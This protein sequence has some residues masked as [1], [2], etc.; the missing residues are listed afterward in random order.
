MIGETNSKICR[1]NF[2]LNF[3][4]VLGLVL[5]LMLA[6]GTFAGAA[7]PGHFGY[8]NKATPELIAGWNIDVRGDDGVGLPGQHRRRS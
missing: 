8:G 5:G 7:E 4:L 2:G 3:G 6:A 1:F